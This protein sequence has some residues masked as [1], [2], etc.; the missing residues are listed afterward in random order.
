MN[1][2]PIRCHAVCARLLEKNLLDVH[3]HC[4]ELK[5][6]GIVSLSSVR[7]GY[8][9]LVVGVED[10]HPKELGGESRDAPLPLM[11]ANASRF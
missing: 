7:M 5:A 1:P 11:V 9:K 3:V 8:E 10:F 2:A 4:S 6:D